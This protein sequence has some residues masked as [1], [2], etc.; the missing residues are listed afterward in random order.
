LRTKLN[1]MKKI[2]TISAILMIGL[3]YCYSQ[4]LSPTMIS[5]QG[6]FDQ[7]ENMTIEWVL[8]ENII[9]TVT[10]KNNIFTQGFL[11]PSIKNELKKLQFI[12]T[13]T[14][15]EILI[16]PNPVHSQFNIIINSNLTFPY[17]FIIYDGLGRSI[18][19]ATF[20]KDDFKH[21]IDISYLST[22]IYYLHTF[23][24]SGVLLK[25]N[26]IIKN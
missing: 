24:S 7:I 21:R 22:G 12:E 17:S 25:I 5:S 20:T 23:D 4:N 15:L 16:A 26:K 3:S 11:Q 8:G 18:K 1:Y 2:F 13:L 19:N 10:Q 9:E 14:S 6:S